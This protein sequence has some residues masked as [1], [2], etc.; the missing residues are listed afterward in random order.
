MEDEGSRQALTKLYGS[1]ADQISIIM[2]KAYVPT[3]EAYL[4]ENIK[5]R[6]LLAKA[7]LN[8]SDAQ[9]YAFNLNDAL[10]L[11]KAYFDNDHQVTKTV[12]ND[13]NELLQKSVDLDTPT[14]LS[15]S[16]LFNKFAK[17]RILEPIDVVN[18][19][20]QQ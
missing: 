20:E 19:G 15:S 13:I 16:A 5:T 12:I 2:E 6:I 17:E 11:V 4:R 7:D 1:S 3:Q 8:Y 18:R 10:S 9:D 14:V